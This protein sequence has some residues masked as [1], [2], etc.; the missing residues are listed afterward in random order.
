MKFQKLHHTY[1]H[2]DKEDS[3]H[4][5]EISTMNKLNDTVTHHSE[6]GGCHPVVITRQVRIV[7]VD[8]SAM[9]ARA[10]LELEA[11]T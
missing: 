8:G 10:L 7:S 3:K 5:K 9:Q 11:S 1:I 6:L 4:I 2:T